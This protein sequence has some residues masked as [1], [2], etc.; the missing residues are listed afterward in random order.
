[1]II[2]VISG[3]CCPYCHAFEPQT[4]DEGFRPDTQQDTPVPDDPIRTIRISDAKAG[5]VSRGFWH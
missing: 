2:R 4:I 3:G 5:L 1:M